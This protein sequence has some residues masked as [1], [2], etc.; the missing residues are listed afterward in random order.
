MA[1]RHLTSE[2]LVLTV[3][4][5][6]VVGVLAVA[7][8]SLAF[9][10]TGTADQPQ[11]DADVQ[12]R[13]QSIDGVNA[14]QTTTITRNGTVASRTTYDAALRPGTQKK[15]LV[16]VNSTVERYD[17]RVSNGSMLWL[18]D[19]RRA[20]ATRISLSKTD[21]D[22]GE[23]LQRLF[24]NLNMETTTDTTTDS[25][26]VE[27]LPVVPR[28]EQRP[29]VSAGS[30]SVSY[31]GTE[32][33]DGRDAYV[34]HV[35]PKDDTAAY[36]QTVWVDTEQ[37]FPVKKRTA[38]TADGE[39]TVVTTTHTN[40]TYDTGVSE[41]VFTPNFPDNTTVT[42]PETPE[43]QTYESVGALEADTEIQV[44]EPDI[45]PGYELTYAT[46]TRGRIHS[47]GL[48]YMNRTSLITVGK[49]DRPANRDSASGAVTIDGQP[50][51]VSYGLTTSVSWSCERYRYTVRGEGVSAD[52]LVTVGQS[53]GCPGGE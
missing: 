1:T 15:R 40:V 19:Q 21:S 37:F 39:R 8:W 14:T 31:R 34:I 23:R 6:V 29:T 32:S 35:A 33:I 18:Y 12:Q 38:W 3:A 44:P 27:P 49:Y 7:I 51:Q 45:P 22:Q 17:R 4:T 36:E 48:R 20:K 13:Y 26:S 9:A 2:R 25:P 50:A 47:V 43:R 53:I 41:D 52:R 30:M 10:S 24:A 42:V 28:S 5:V 16:V 11:I 46:Q